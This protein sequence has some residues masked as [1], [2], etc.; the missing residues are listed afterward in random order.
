MANAQGWTKI[1]SGTSEWLLSVCFPT[2]DIGYVVGWSGTILKTSN[3]GSS[4]TQQSSG[5]FNV[6]HSVA[7]CNANIG[8]VAGEYG[9]V[10]KTVDGGTHWMDV[11]PGISEPLL[12]VSFP[13]TVNGFVSGGAFL[14]T[15]DA[16][17]TWPVYL[18]G[19]PD[20][21]SCIYFQNVDTGF[22]TTYSGNIMKTV[23]GGLTW[24]TVHNAFGRLNSIYFTNESRGIAVGENAAGKAVILKTTDGGLTWDNNT[25]D[26]LPSLSS[27]HFPCPDTGYAVGGDGTILKSTNRG[28]SWVHQFSG[29]NLWLKAVCFFDKDNGLIAG[30]SG[31]ILKTNDGGVLGIAEFAENKHT[32]NIYPNP[33][34]DILWIEMPADTKKIIASI[35]DIHG[36]SVITENL[37]GE[38]ISINIK[39]L[40]S[41]VYMI[42]LFSDRN[43]IIERFIKE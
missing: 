27:V 11:S 20:W 12:S 34:K 43:I 21:Y 3:G 7:F 1:N 6:L 40:P 35:I 42:R 38:R 28:G 17:I 15:P 39:D 25:F 41:G 24:T 4:W 16:G 18:S 14:G 26:N 19:M 8:Y 37:S 30:T 36:R 2:K 29:T 9:T 23:N 13:T 10:L 5:T 22:A 31:L 32:C 33:S